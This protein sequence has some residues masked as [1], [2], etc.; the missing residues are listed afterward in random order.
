M[1][2]MPGSKISSPR[3][4]QLPKTPKNLEINVSPAAQKYLAD[5]RKLTLDMT[6]YTIIP[7][8]TIRKLYFRVALVGILGI[9]I[10]LGLGWLFF[11]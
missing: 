3:P 7:A 2:E 9:G 8:I 11:K 6:K 10:G 4:A 5:L 1:L